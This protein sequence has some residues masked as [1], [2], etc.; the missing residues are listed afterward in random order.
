MTATVRFDADR[1]LYFVDGE[2]IPNATRIIGGLNLHDST[3]FTAAAAERGRYIHE[4]IH[5]W[6]QDDLEMVSVYEPYKGYVDSAIRLVE[7]SGVKKSDV[8]TEIRVYHPALRY[9]GTA[10]WI[11]PYAGDDSCLDWKSGLIGKPTGIQT[12]LY[13][14]AEP[15][16]NG[17]R[18]RRYGAQLKANGRLPNVRALDR[19]PYD[20]TG[21][22]YHRAAAAVDLYREFIWE[23]EKKELLNAA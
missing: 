21:Y 19:R 3:Y 9:C 1:H 7:A 6:M 18:R 11:G 13:D 5:L 16:P 4:C 15:L 2:L 10:D 20:D 17:R 8:R 22:D 12:A 14:M 23:R